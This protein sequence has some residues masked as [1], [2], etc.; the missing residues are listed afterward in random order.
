MSGPLVSVVIPTRD[1]AARIKRTLDSVLAQ[2]YANIEVIVVDDG[3][4]DHTEA[5][6]RALRDARIRYERKPAP[7]GAARARNYGAQLASGPLLAFN[8]CGDEWTPEKLEDQVR[9]MGRMP[10]NVAMVYSSLCRVFADGKRQPLNCPVFEHDEPGVYRRALAMGVSG[11]YPQTAL[12]RTEA[13]RALGGFDESFRC[14]EDLEFF[15]RLAKVYKLQFMPG[16]ST[17]LYDDS[18]GVSSNL[19][20]LYEAHIGILKKF[21][22]DLG[23]DPELL[24]PH[25]RGAGRNLV[26]SRH[27]KYAREILW[28]AARSKRPQALD[29]AFLALSYGGRPAHWAVRKARRAL[30]ALRGSPPPLDANGGIGA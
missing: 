10:D 28:K 11:I 9:V 12:L 30:W 3:S 26:A 19:D 2:A 17:M 18:R 1:R 14:W 13:F 21:E 29:F 16:Y 8:D 6:V 25:Y 23:G 5:V 7:H 4:T 24:V 15:L 22:A 27:A 20:N